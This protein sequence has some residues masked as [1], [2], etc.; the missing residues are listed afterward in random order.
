MITYTAIAR[1]F[2]AGES[3]QTIARSLYDRHDHRDPRRPVFLYS[4]RD[5]VEH[6]IRV[7][8]QRQSRRR[9]D[10]PYVVRRGKPAPWT[11]RP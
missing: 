2:K 3:M 6:A 11:E 10:S 9:L 1:R 5:V 4:F 8:L 7:V